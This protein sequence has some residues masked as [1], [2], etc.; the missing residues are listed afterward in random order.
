MI[1][2][3]VNRGT[4]GSLSRSPSEEAAR[5]D[6]P[7]GSSPRLFST[8]ALASPSTLASLPCLWYSQLISDSSEPSG[9]SSARRTNPRESTYAF[10]LYSRLLMMPSSVPRSLS[11][12]GSQNQLLY[13]PK[14]PAHRVRERTLTIQANNQIGYIRFFHQDEPLNRNQSLE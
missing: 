6:A 14:N 9:I 1:P 5:G 2:P 4:A 11:Y 8:N 12:A 10:S 3:V 13:P 7:C